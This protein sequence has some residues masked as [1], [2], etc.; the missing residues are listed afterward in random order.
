MHFSFRKRL[1][2]DRGGCRSISSKGL[3]S[4]IVSIFHA[5]HFLV[6]KITSKKREVV[7]SRHVDGLLRATRTL[8]NMNEKKGDSCGRVRVM[9]PLVVSTNLT[10][11]TTTEPAT[12]LSHFRFRNASSWWYWRGRWRGIYDSSVWCEG[13]RCCTCH[14]KHLALCVGLAKIKSMCKSRSSIR[15]PH[16]LIHFTLH[17][18]PHFLPH[19]SMCTSEHLQVDLGTLSRPQQMVGSKDFVFPI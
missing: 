3:V 5:N 14:C 9:S 12:F 10:L 17:S 19:L 13:S 6:L 18:N 7:S 16:I 1:V 11:G 4:A 8:L 15:K 2:K